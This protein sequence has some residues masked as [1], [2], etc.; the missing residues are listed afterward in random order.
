MNASGAALTAGRPKRVLTYRRI[1]GEIEADILARRL[2]PGDRL[3]AERDLAG[4]YGASRRTLREA[5]RLLEQKGLLRIKPGVAGGAFVQDLDA[6]VVSQSLALVLRHQKIPLAD[7]SQF[8]LDVEGL[9]ARR[10][11]EKI[12][13]EDAAGLRDLIAQAG[14]VFEAAEFD[15]RRLMD[16]DRRIHLELARIAGNRLHGL[17]L[18]T[19]HDNIS[20]YY[21]TLMTKDPAVQRNNLRE[22]EAL[23]EAVSQG[24]GDRAEDLARDH[25]EKGA[26]VME[27]GLETND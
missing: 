8:R 25:V 17:V 23:V 11:A 27:R 26:K 1:A 2:L 9:T 12:K 14:A 15:W 21:E 6:G 5:L 16:L 24:D 20:P 3:K 13:P 19:V 18:Q 7:L 4:A 10:A 22:L